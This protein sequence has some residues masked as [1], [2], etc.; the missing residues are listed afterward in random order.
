MSVAERRTGGQRAD[1]S[2]HRPGFWCV[3]GRSWAFT[4]AAYDD[5]TAPPDAF[6]SG[7]GVEPRP[8]APRAARSA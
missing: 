6:G 2:L 3:G 8:V 4:D 7:L 1:P 5:A